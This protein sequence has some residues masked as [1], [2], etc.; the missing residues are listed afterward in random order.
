MRIVYN[1]DGRPSGD[2]VAEFESDDQAEKAMGRNRE[3]LGNRFIILTREDAGSNNS[4]DGGSPNGGGG[5]G[6][7][8]NSGRMVVR[9]GGLPYRATVREIMD[10]FQPESECAH[11]RILMN[12]DG[13]P[14]GEALA[15]FDTKELADQAMGKNRQYM[16]DRFVILTAQ[17]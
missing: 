17:Y 10:W 5:G 14:S 15:E 16:K 12:R 1:R 9:M 2:A 3:H 4:F 7:G 6:G 13:R 8:S 11:V